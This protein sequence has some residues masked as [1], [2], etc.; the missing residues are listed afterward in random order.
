VQNLCTPVRTPV[1]FDD[2][3]GG[4]GAIRMDGRFAVT[5]A[6]LPPEPDMPASAGSSVDLQQCG[7]QLD[8]RLGAGSS[9]LSTNGAFFN[10]TAI[11]TGGLGQRHG[12]EFTNRN[13]ITALAL[14]SLR[15]LRIRKPSV[16]RRSGP[17]RSAGQ[18]GLTTR[19]L[20][21]LD[22][23]GRVWVAAAPNA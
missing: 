7:S 6:D 5:F 8:L 9:T 23:A 17:L 10:A 13:P 15:Q 1:S 2:H 19:H 20:Y 4:L 3:A 18:A 14:P 12:N 16:L 22:G 11:L 21:L